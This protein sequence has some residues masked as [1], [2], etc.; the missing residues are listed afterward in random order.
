MSV[1]I[2][3]SGRTTG[4]SLTSGCLLFVS[5]DRDYSHLGILVATDSNER[6]PEAPSR[7]KPTNSFRVRNWV[8]LNPRCADVS[9]TRPDISVGVLIAVIGETEVEDKRV[10][11]LRIAER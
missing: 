1:E 5:L 3:E 10:R 7:G 8:C 4:T 11:P 6:V 2:G 9:V